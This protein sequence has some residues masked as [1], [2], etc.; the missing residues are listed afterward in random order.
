MEMARSHERRE[1][2]GRSS[3]S[4]PKQK[5]SFSA[6]HTFLL[7]SF[8]QQTNL[9]VLVDLERRSK[10][11]SKRKR[12]LGLLPELIHIVLGL[13]ETNRSLSRKPSEHNSNPLAKACWKEHRSTTLL[14]YPSTFWKEHRSTTQLFN[15]LSLS[16]IE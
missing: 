11:P 15:F 1:D 3:H 13:Q 6:T 8:L 5:G 12:K 4:S 9:R 10:T 2:S 14:V 16:V 7:S